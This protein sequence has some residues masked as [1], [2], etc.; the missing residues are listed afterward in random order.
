MAIF[1]SSWYQKE[2]SEETAKKKLT[3][4]MIRCFKWNTCYLNTCEILYFE[5]LLAV[6]RAEACVLRTKFL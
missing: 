2:H 5:D 6:G 1:N 4:A 3:K